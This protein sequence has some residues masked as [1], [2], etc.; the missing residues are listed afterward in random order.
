MVEFEVLLISLD[1]FVAVTE[2]SERQRDLKF[3]GGFLLQFQRFLPRPLLRCP[4]FLLLPCGAIGRLACDAWDGVP[5]IILELVFSSRPSGRA[6]LRCLKP[7]GVQV[8][9]AAFFFLPSLQWG[10]MWRCTAEERPWLETTPVQAVFPEGFLCFS[11]EFWGCLCKSVGTAVLVAS[12]G[13][14]ACLYVLVLL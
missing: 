4:L 7:Y 1:L 5:A 13:A 8:G 12:R 11:F 3:H 2:D 14:C 10:K 9:R 6:L